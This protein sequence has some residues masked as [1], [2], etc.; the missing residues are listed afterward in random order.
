MVGPWL[1]DGGGVGEERL[2]EEAMGYALAES[3]KATAEASTLGQDI[4]SYLSPAHRDQLGQGCALAALACE[5]PRQSAGVR[6]M[7][8]AGLRGMLNHMTCKAE[9]SR[10]A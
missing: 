2:V 7:F 9:P 10:L 3:G 5:M 6:R 1:K 4:A 8:T